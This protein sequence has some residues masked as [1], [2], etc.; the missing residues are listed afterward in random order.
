MAEYFDPWARG[1]IDY[2]SISEKVLFTR[3][4]QVVAWCLEITAD[5]LDPKLRS[6][7]LLP[8]LF[9][10]GGD[11]LVCDV[12]HSRALC[13]GRKSNETT[14]RHPDLFGGRLLAYFPD[15]ELSDGIAEIESKGFL[16]FTTR[17][18]GIHGLRILKTK[19]TQ[20][21]TAETICLRMCRLS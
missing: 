15:E 17:L 9:H 11:D 6:D 3:T 13:L 8:R 21:N 16:I 20:M 10:R 18:H 12:G 5:D 2:A 7:R 1:S 19:T 4:M 14:E